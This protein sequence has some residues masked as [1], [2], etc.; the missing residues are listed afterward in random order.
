MNISPI[1]LLVIGVSFS[2]FYALII[3]IGW[4]M[5]RRNRKK[6][7]QFVGLN[8]IELY[9]LETGRSLNK[10]VQAVSLSN[11]HFKDEKGNKIEPEKFNCY[12]V[13]KVSAEFPKIKKGNLIFLN[14]QTHKI[15]YAFDIPNIENY[16]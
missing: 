6:F 3:T 12:I 15:D 10:Y 7:H 2:L 9:D 14:L 4:A 8:K 11:N 13:E 5:T 1:L 16:R